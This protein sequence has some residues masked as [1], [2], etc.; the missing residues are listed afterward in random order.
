MHRWW[1]GVHKS[2]ASTFACGHAVMH[3]R[4]EWFAHAAQG[5]HEREGAG[6]G[7]RLLAADQAHTPVL[8]GIPARD[9]GGAAAGCTIR[10]SGLGD[11]TFSQ[12]KKKKKKKYS[13]TQTVQKWS[14]CTPVFLKEIFP[15]V[16]KQYCKWHI[17]LIAL[18][19]WIRHAQ[20]CGHGKW[21]VGMEPGFR[22]SHEAATG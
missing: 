14:W 4:G 9:H 19:S 18:S 3:A 16:I 8:R 5:L 6:H 13:V 21:E 22:A 11:F 15:C 12:T 7:I 1:G 10:G 17:I 2:R 20:C